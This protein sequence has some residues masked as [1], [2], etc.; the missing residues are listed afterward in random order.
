METPME[1]SEKAEIIR[2]WIDPQERITV[3]FEDER[4]LSA[5]VVECDGLTVTI[6]LQTAFPL[7][8]ST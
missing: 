1:S 7:T 5:E 2:R 4:D 6:L 3:D 8:N